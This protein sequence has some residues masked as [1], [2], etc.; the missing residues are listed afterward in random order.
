MA[1]GEVGCDWGF[2]ENLAYATLLAAEFPR[3]A[4][5][6]GQ[7]PRHVLPPPCGADRSDDGRG[8]RA[9]GARCERSARI[10]D[11]RFVV[12]RRSRARLRVRLQHHGARYA[13][14]LG[15]PVRR[16]REWRAGRDR[17]VHQLRRSQVGPA[18]RSHAVPAA[19]L[20][21]AG[22]GAFLRATRAF[23]AAVR[24]AQHAGGRAVDAGA[25]VPHAAAPDAAWVAQAAR[26]HD[27]EELAAAQVVGVEPGRSRARSVPTRS[28]TRSSRSP[29]TPSRASCSAAAKCISISPNRGATTTSRTLR[30]CVSKN[31]IRSRS[32]SM[33]GSSRATATPRKSFGA[34]RSRRTRVPGIKSGIAFRSRCLRGTSCSTR[35]ALARLRRLP[36]STHCTSDSSRRWLQR[37]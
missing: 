8:L 32:K 17:P 11:C 19:R 15:R 7:S 31:C 5:R 33:L 1:A 6:P 28:S 29:T 20:R 36:V 25:D 9:A 12:V 16:L 18:V 22:A 34:K 37:R 4:D 21:G 10:H 24:G 26:R 2:A 3:A 13:R 30:S 14:D 27:A 35:V 23:P